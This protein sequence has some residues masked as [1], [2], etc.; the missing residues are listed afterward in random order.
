MLEP[1]Y[2]AKSSI[3]GRMAAAVSSTSCDG[4]CRWFRLRGGCC[5]RD[6]AGCMH[7]DT[8]VTCNG[9]SKRGGGATK[10]GWQ[11]GQPGIGSR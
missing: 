2:E 3:R 8:E 7:R 5:R 11:W 4:V 10:N 1:E 6:G 9:G